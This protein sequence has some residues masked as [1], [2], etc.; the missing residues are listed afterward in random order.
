MERL[1]RELNF[2]NLIDRKTL[3]KHETTIFAKKSIVKYNEIELNAPIQIPLINN[4]QEYIEENKGGFKKCCNDFKG[5]WLIKKAPPLKETKSDYEQ[6]LDFV[7]S[8]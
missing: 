6:F 3:S 7:I 1:K 4:N 2:K 8:L 5:F